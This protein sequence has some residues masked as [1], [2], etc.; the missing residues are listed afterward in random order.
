MKYPP[1]IQTHPDV[2]MD[3]CHI[4]LV[5]AVMMAAKPQSIVEIG[6]GSGA[7]TMALI[8]LSFRI[9]HPVS[10]T[11]VDGFNDW[12]FERPAG[13]S[14]IEPWV[15]LRKMDERDFVQGSRAAGDLYD[16]VISDA[17][18]AHTGEWAEDTCE[19]VT[20]G[21]ILIFHDSDSV[22]CPS[23]RHAVNVARRSGMQELLFNKNS[24][25]NERCHRGISILQKPIK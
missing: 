12:N 9:G 1:V 14:A 19:I 18:H 24:L 2:R 3:D 13:L 16:F 22:H 5:C 11:V 10:I 25:P 6:L 8:S 4:E 20:P 23:V 7:L 15:L 21:G 17:D